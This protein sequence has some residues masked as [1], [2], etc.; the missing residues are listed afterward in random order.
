MA[1]NVDNQVTPLL[2]DWGVAKQLFM[3]FLKVFA[4]LVLPHQKN[5]LAAHHSLIHHLDKSLKLLFKKMLKIVGFVQQ[6]LQL[7]GQLVQNNLF[8]QLQYVVPSKK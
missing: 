3:I 8:L 1:G 2:I 7:F 4:K 5:E 6:K